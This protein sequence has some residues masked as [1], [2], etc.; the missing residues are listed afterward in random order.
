MPGLGSM[1]NFLWRYLITSYPLI[2]WLIFSCRRMI[3][4]RKFWIIL[5][6]KVCA[7]LD[8]MLDTVSKVLY[9]LAYNCVCL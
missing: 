4:S 2:G 6:L 1:W 5:R 9:V 8:S 3:M 7:V